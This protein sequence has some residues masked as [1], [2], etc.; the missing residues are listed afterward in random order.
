MNQ[1]TAAKIYETALLISRIALMNLIWILFV[2]MGAGVFGFLPATV[3]LYGVFRKAQRQQ[4]EF[5]W[6]AYAFSRFFLYLEKLFWV[7]LGLAFICL[8]LVLS[9]YTLGQQHL[10]F[11]RLIAAFLVYILFLVVPNFS[12]NM[13]H[14]DVPLFSL[15]KNSFLLPLFWGTSSLKIAAAFFGT[16]VL[17]YLIPGI[18]PF[19]SAAVPI[20]VSGNILLKRWEKQLIR[21]EKR[22]EEDCA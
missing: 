1:K 19:F 21:L 18:I 16:A 12:V 7:S 20:Y 10:V 22:G 8:S 4:G 17:C 13:V 5:K 2:I 6:L 11:N 15:V 3:S 14:L 9:Y